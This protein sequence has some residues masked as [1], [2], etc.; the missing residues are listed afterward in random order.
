M[1]SS[2]F[3]EKKINNMNFNMSNDLHMTDQTIQQT[4][5]YFSD[6][7]SGWVGWA[8]WEFR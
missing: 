5:Y 4:E 1:M 2:H 3:S 6:A 7:A 8:V